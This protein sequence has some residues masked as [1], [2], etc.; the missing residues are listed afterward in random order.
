VNPALVLVDVIRAFFDPAGVNY[1]PEV[2]AVEAP[3]ARLLRA[4]RERDRLVVHAVERHRP[5]LRDF[6]QP[7]LPEHCLIGGRDAEFWPGFGP[8]AREREIVVPKRRYSAFFA[9]DL[10][11]VL[12]EQGVD[13][14]VVAGVKTNVCVRAT[15]QDAFANG[16]RVV[17]PP[18]ATSSNRPALGAA[19]LEDVGRYLGETPSLDEVLA[20]L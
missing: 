9:T 3:I 16:L 20:W 10:A 19:S 5:G 18:E 17:L 7:K 8:V 1:Y 4:A 12:R 14:V 11:L 15:C 2:H 6:E 13:T